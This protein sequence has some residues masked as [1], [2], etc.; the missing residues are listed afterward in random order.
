MAEKKTTKKEIKLS[1]EAAMTRLNEIVASL[2]D[3]N[4]PL[5]ASLALYEEGVAL[6]RHCNALLE[7]AE[8]QIKVLTR[9][10]SGEIVEANFAPIT[11]EP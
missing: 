11:E 6:V 5:D 9:D 2:E 10:P 8:T 4:A 1:Y 3:G 7:A